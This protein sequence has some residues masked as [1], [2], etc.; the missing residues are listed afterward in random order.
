MVQKEQLSVDNLHKLFLEAL[1]YTYQKFSLS[2][3]FSLSG[4]KVNLYTGNGLLFFHIDT[5]LYTAVEKVARCW[6]NSQQPPTPITL[7]K[8]YLDKSG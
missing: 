8:V 4:W 6:I 7:L 2:V 3:G 1:R 5:D